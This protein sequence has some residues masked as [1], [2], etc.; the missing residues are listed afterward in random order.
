MKSIL[1]P[2]TYAEHGEPPLK[3]GIDSAGVPAS[4][5]KFSL[6]YND[7][8]SP[9]L[10]AGSCTQFPS[11]VHKYR[12][13]TNDIKYNIEAGWFAAMSMMDKRVE[14]RFFPL[15]SM[16]ING[17]PV[18]YVGERGSPFTEIIINGSLKDKKF[19]VYYI[20]GNEITGFMTCGYQNLHL[21][22]WEAM[23]L[24]IMPSAVQ[25]RNGT[26]DYKQIV[27]KVL[28]MRPVIHCK[29][30]EIVK[31]PS[32]M[33]AEFDHELARSEDLTQKIK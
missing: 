3:L 18:Y 10:A 5:I 33:L 7:L 29:R 11:F 27:Q 16:N 12:Y 19:V 21:Y 9:I 31:T 14:F 4:D 30:H 23:K 6:H 24:L 26:M 2:A 17:K 20:Y 32:I 8:F 13:R 15:A 28:Q 22:L 25:L 1:A